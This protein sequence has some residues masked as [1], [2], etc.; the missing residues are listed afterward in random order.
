[1]DQVVFY[2]KLLRAHINGFD[3]TK[4]AS[5]RLEL[6][7]NCRST[8]ELPKSPPDITCQAQQFVARSEGWEIENM[9][10]IEDLD[11]DWLSSLPAELPFNM[12]NF[13]LI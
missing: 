7:A 11:M 8:G 12:H 2:R 3:V 9:P 10:L 6:L 1:M 13:G 4:H 5:I